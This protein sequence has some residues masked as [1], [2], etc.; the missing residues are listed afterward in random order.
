MGYPLPD[1][2]LLASLKTLI[3]ANPLDLYRMEGGRIVDRN[4]DYAEPLK[5]YRFLDGASYSI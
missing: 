2:A 4:P 1:P 5:R 3:G